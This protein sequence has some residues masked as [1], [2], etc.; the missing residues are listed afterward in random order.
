MEHSSN[1][2]EKASKF[3]L[4]TPIYYV[5][6]SPHIGHA[7]TNI[8]ADCMARF[9]R[10]CG[11]DVF[12]LT[13]T[14]EH[15]EKVKK[16]A[17]AAGKDVKSFVDEVSQ[18]FVI[19][20]KYLNISYDSFIRTTDEVHVRV[21]QRA[22]QTLYEKG[23]IYKAKY[24]GYY[25]MPCESFWTDTQVK[26]AG[27]CPDCKRPVEEIEEE[28]YFFKLSKYEPWLRSYLKDNPDF[29]KPSTRYNEVIGFLETS[30]LADQCISR[31]IKRVSWGIPFPFDANYVV[32][33]WFDALLNYI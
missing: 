30:H 11:D 9:R 31:P 23:D 17:D 7:Y 27:G 25:C 21:V 3:Y 22:I 4:T 2:A 16:V 6:A 26:E 14:D 8:I 29:I 24:R 10:L 20:W 28:N 18:N 15:G 12:F 13:G 5:N 32:Y 33:V 19:L 1:K